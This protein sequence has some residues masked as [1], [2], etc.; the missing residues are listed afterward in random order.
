MNANTPVLEGVVGSQAY[1]LAGPGSDVDKLGVF[2][3][4]LDDLLSMQ[5]LKET[6][7]RNDPDLCYHELRKFMNLAAKANPTVLELLY[8]NDYT[9]AS[10]DVGKKLVEHRDLFIS[11]RIRKTYGGYALQQVKRLERRGDGS[12]KSKLRKRKAKHQ[13]HIARL[14]IQCQFALEHGYIRVHLKDHEIELVRRVEAMDDDELLE[15][16]GD[17]DQKIQG[18]PSDLPEDADWSAINDLLLEFRRAQWTQ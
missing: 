18:I 9:I 8:L 4:P 2:V 10:D 6:L 3:A 17:Q 16:F 12:F 1:G 14:V 7:V 13:R 5:P 15:W 11:Q